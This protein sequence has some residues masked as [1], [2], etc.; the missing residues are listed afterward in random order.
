M[1]ND[2]MMLFKVSNLW[3]G[4]IWKF[5][6]GPFPLHSSVIAI[7][8]RIHGNVLAEDEHFDLK[9]VRLF[10]NGNNSTWKPSA[11]F[12]YSSYNT[13]RRIAKIAIFPSISQFNVQ[14]PPGTSDLVYL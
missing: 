8:S 2:G 13:S 9:L 5:E 7:V 14:C 12:D 3:N 10:N 11:I 1:H 6:L 4:F